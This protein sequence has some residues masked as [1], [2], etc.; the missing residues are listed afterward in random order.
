MYKFFVLSIPLLAY[1]WMTDPMLQAPTPSSVNVVWFTD[2]VGEANFVEYG[3]G[4]SKTAVCKTIELSRIREESTDG[5]AWVFQPVYRHEATLQR[6]G[7]K[8]PYQVVSVDSSGKRMKSEVFLCN[9][10]PQKG[11][12]LKILLT[13]DH[14]GKPMVAANLQ[15]VRKVVPEIDAIFFAGDCVD[16]PDKAS[17]WFGENG[18]FACLQGRAKK[19]L[20]ASVYQGGALLQYAPMFCAIG[21]HEVM[22]RWSTKTTLD[23]QFNDPYPRLQQEYDLESVKDRSFNTDTYEEIFHLPKYY[24]ASFG[25]VRLVVLYATRIWRSPQLGVKGKYTENPASYTRPEEWGYGDFI[26]EPIQKGSAQ[27]A[28]LEKE[29]QSSE[30]QQAKYKIVMLHNPLHSLG[31]NSI[32]PYTDPVQKVAKNSSGEVTAIC[33]HYPK[34]QDVLIRDIEPLFAQYGVDLVLCG[35]THIWNRFQSPTG[36]HHLETSNV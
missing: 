29:L 22:G 5:R 28:W 27:Y 21:N 33:Y 2:G 36:V 3:E 14:Q 31:E 25:D 16:H 10:S 12:S 17:E 26:F 6:I 35:H 13:S 23:A 34:D 24:A 19:E 11:K 1:G 9:P 30:F 32:P 8:T 15:K 7:E 4:L 18:F 20:H